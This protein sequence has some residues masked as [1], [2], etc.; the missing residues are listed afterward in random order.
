MASKG[1]MMGLMN[2]G[3][4]GNSGSKSRE[5]SMDFLKNLKLENKSK[6]YSSSNKSSFIGGGTGANG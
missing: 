5:T 4:S 2:S 6:A 1:N 3:G